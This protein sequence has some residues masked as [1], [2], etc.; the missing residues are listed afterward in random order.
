[1]HG[2]PII[3]QTLAHFQ[4][5]PHIDEIY[6]V[7]VAEY[8]PHME[9]LAEEFGIT[10]VKEIIPGGAS[11]QDSIYNGLICARAHNEDDAIVLIHDGVRPMISGDL[12]TRNI[13]SVEQYGNG[14]TCCKSN[15]TVVLSGDGRR[16][17]DVP[18]RDHAYNAVA[19]Q[20]FRLG[21]IIEAHEAERATNPG[22]ENI[23]DACTM[24]HRQ[25]KPVYIVE[26]SNENIKI[27]T[28][29]DYY[30]LLALLQYHESKDAL[31]V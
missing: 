29:E 24:L 9:A 22:Y 27:T 23:V 4:R 13:E 2:K 5:H 17:G 31:G 30:I 20:S 25:G 6:I 18:V 8:I 19:P 16:V 12:I 7:S 28:P 21:A 1:V 14:V 11:S 10:K 26:G 3:I 15:I